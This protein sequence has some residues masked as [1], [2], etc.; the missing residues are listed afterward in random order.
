MGIGEESIWVHKPQD[1]GTRQ[2][3][4]CELMEEKGAL[5]YGQEC[6]MDALDTLCSQ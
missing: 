5:R 6:T 3:N 1:A 2:N 4:I